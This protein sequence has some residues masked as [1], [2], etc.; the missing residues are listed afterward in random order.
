MDMDD[1]RLKI[2]QLEIDIA[3]LRLEQW[4]RLCP[5]GPCDEDEKVSRDHLRD[6]LDAALA[7]YRRF[8]VDVDVDDDGAADDDAA[9]PGPSEK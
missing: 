1:L 8:V 2:L 4:D 7:A 6:K 5:A 3:A 9:D